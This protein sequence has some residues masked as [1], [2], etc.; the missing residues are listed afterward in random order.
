MP[1]DK[2][3][4]DHGYGTVDVVKDPLYKRLKTLGLTDKQVHRIR[5][6]KEA[7]ISKSGSVTIKL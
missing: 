7:K 1:I 5:K 6:N 4:E 2:Y 3:L